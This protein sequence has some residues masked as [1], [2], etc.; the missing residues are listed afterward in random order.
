MDGTFTVPKSKKDDFRTLLSDIKWQHTPLAVLSLINEGD[1]DELSKYI[2]L[3]GNQYDETRASMLKIIA[4]TDRSMQHSI[5]KDVH[6]LNMI[7]K[8]SEL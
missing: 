1:L 3:D 6:L 2:L 5:N 7:I 8:L 4:D